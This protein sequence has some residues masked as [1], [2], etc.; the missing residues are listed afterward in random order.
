MSGSSPF[1]DNPDPKPPLGPMNQKM[2][3]RCDSE[4]N[5]Q[6]QM[7]PGT[8]KAGNGCRI[9]KDGRSRES[10]PAGVTP[11][12]EIEMIHKNNGHIIEQ[13]RCQNFIYLPVRS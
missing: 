6:S 4:R 2:Q 7:N 1:T 10:K 3:Y 12:S 5:K 11:G 9:W 13:Q 8:E